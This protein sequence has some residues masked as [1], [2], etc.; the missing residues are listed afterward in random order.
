MTEKAYRD[1]FINKNDTTALDEVLMG[2]CLDIDVEEDGKIDL[3]DLEDLIMVILEKIGGIM[4]DREE[5]RKMMGKFVKR[6]TQRLIQFRQIDQ[7]RN[8][9]LEIL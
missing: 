4:P 6:S 7:I 2:F 5:V 8:I 3:W 9:I 1:L